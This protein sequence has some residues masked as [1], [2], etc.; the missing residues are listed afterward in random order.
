MSKNSSPLFER[1][2]DFLYSDVLCVDSLA[3]QDI[4]V[5][6][7]GFNVYFA[8]VQ[9]QHGHAEVVAAVYLAAA[10]D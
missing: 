7:N 6:I 1:S 4:A 8:V 3:E 5:N 10:Y 9:G 2:G